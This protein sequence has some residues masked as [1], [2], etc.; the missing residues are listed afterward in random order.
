MEKSKIIKIITIILMTGVYLILWLFPVKSF[1][2]FDKLINVQY[3]PSAQQLIEVEKSLFLLPGPKTLWVVRTDMGFDVYRNMGSAISRKNGPY[4]ALGLEEIKRRNFFSF[5]DK[6]IPAALSGKHFRKDG[7][8]PL[9]LAVGSNNQAEVLTRIKQGEDVNEADMN[10]HWT[11]LLVAVDKNNIEIAALLLESGANVNAVNR[12]GESAL[13]HLSRNEN[14][15]KMA[16]LLVK[17]G[18]DVNIKGRMGTTALNSP[19]L[20]HAIWNDRVDM[21]KFLIAK[22]ADIYYENNDKESYLFHNKNKDLVKYLLEKGLDANKRSKSNTT[23]LFFV[24]SVEIASLLIAHGADVNAKNDHGLSP[25]FSNR[26]KDVCDLLI[27]KGANLSA[28]DKNGCSGLFHVSDPV[29]YE[30]FIRKGLNVNERNKYGQTPLHEVVVRLSEP[31]KGQIVKILLD[32][33][34]EVNVRDDYNKTPLHYATGEKT[35]ALLKKYGAR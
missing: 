33:G 14:N 16:D 34:A 19:P 2:R 25:L 31:E 3:K 15:V 32:N 27:K 7:F 18:A 12:Y 20:Y 10:G 6:S 35:V 26:L 28:K 17:H 8:T 11:P 4:S 21:A 24:G 13:T 9:I 1:Y 22:G 30:M 29:L 23:P 5:I